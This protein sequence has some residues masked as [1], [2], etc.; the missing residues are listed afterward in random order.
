MN[1][2]TTSSTTG[3]F[4]ANPILRKPHGEDGVK[5]ITNILATEKGF[6]LPHVTGEYVL[7]QSSLGVLLQVCYK[8]M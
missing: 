6:T 3:M 8:I 5:M 2:T 1:Y 4:P 7:N